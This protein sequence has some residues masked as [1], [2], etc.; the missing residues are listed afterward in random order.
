MRRI[1]DSSAAANFLRLRATLRLRSDENSRR[2]SR[3]TF[4]HLV[5][6]KLEFVKNILFAAHRGKLE[7]NK[8]KC[9]KDKYCDQSS[10]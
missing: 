2:F 5:A 10:P 7:Q 1:S 9:N 3:L 4:I 6:I 8:E